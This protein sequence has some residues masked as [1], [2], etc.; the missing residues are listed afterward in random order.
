MMKTAYILVFIFVSFLTV[1]TVVIIIDEHTD[2]SFVFSTTEEE[3]AKNNI[4][5]EFTFNAPRT[6]QFSIDYLS[7]NIMIWHKEKHELQSLYPEVTSPPPEL[8]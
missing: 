1:P 6:N 3:H 2:I 5:I 8:V 4:T 7:K